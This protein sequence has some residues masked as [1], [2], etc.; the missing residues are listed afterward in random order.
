MEIAISSDENEAFCHECEEAGCEGDS[1]CQVE[2]DPVVCD[3]GT[4]LA[5]AMK[6]GCDC[7]AIERPAPTEPAPPPDWA[8]P[9]EWDRRYP[10]GR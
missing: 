5:H 9:T 2:C 10:P 8:E 3:C 4:C 6:F 7:G 1:E